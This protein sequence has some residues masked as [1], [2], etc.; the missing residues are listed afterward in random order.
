MFKRSR[1]L[2]GS[3]IMKID[4]SE[5]RRVYLVH[6]SVEILPEAW[7]KLKI[8]SE[9][10]GVSLRDYLTFLIQR[11]EPVL[12]GDSDERAILRSIVQSNKQGTR[13]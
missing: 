11:S 4:K 3:R 12:D 10:S 5:S 6:K 8:H 2:L 9:L 13:A 7:K 1:D